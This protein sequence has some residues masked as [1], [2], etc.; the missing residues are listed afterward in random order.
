MTYFLSYGT[1]RNEYQVW[2]YGLLKCRHIEPRGIKEYM[3][4]QLKINPDLELVGVGEMDGLAKKII[5]ELR[6]PKATTE[7]MERIL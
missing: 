3:Q 7:T 2:Q 4:L 6:E 1:K 5:A